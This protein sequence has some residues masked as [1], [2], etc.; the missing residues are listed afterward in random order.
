VQKI[1]FL[2]RSLLVTLRPARGQRAYGAIRHTTRNHG[3][4]VCLDSSTRYQKETFFSIIWT[5]VFFRYLAEYQ[6]PWE[7]AFRQ[8]RQAVS[9]HREYFVTQCRHDNTAPPPDVP[10]ISVLGTER[11]QYPGSLEQVCKKSFANVMK[12]KAHY[13]SL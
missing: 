3:C 6:T 11:L 7:Y 5:I 9:A 13:I 2:S 4:A 10:S 1:T 12:R 8:R